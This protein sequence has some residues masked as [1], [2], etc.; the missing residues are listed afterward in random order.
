MDDIFASMF[1]GAAFSYDTAGPGPG[2][3]RKPTRGRDTD[4]K[5]E[6]SLEEVYKGKKVVMMLERDRICGGC[7]G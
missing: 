7:K 4:V 3:R 6:I 2:S 5:Y 1:G